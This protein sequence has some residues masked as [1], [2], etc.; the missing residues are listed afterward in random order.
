MVRGRKSAWDRGM[1]TALEFKKMK[2]RIKD[3]PLIFGGEKRHIPREKRRVI[4][5]NARK[6]KE[7]KF[8]SSK[9]LNNQWLLGFFS[10]LKKE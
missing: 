6:A 8:L 2:K 1:L 5:S 3:P 10:E 9:R 7:G 4:A